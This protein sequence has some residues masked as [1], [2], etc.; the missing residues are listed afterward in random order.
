MIGEAERKRVLAWYDANGRNLPWRTSRDPY[1]VWVSE[2][3]LHQTQVASML[4]RYERWMAA[5]PT[6]EALA[7]ADAQHALAIWEGLGYYRRCRY[8]LEGARQIQAKGLPKTSE[9][10]RNLPGIG[11]YT[12]NAIAS[13]AF[14]ES[15][16]VVDG[17][18]ER[19]FARFSACGASDTPLRKLAW[20]WATRALDR[21]RPGDWNQALMELGATVCVP[22]HPKCPLCPLERGCAAR[23]S[24]RVEAFPA[25]RTTQT[26]V[27]LANVVWV[28]FIDGRV[29]VREIAPGAWGEGRWEFPRADATSDPPGAEA[30]LRGLVGEGWLESLGDVRHTVTRH[31]IVVSASLVRCA[32]ASEQLCWKTPNELEDLPMPAPQRKILRLA[33]RV[34]GMG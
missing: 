29:G 28:P 26:A 13:I 20:E 12:A 17:N 19:V 5:Y 4:P 22:K 3:M 1:A 27:P 21:T 14:D 25:P 33:L 9:A 23:Q 6:V 15:V 10:W 11:E 34:L 31:R 32:S 2:M 8:L 18:V 16:P 7:Q 24:W 30:S